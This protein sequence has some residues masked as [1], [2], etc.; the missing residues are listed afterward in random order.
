MPR[1][2]KTTNLPLYL[3]GANSEMYSGEINDPIPTPEPMIKR[4]TIMVHT[5]SA[6]HWMMA[7]TMNI[8]LEI[9]KRGFLPEK[10]TIKPE[11]KA[12]MNA[13]REVAA[14]MNCSSP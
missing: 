9:I 1:Q 6:A 4:P 13:P 8:R 14:V 7:P 12:V 10:S 5:D 11:S 3:E 2:F